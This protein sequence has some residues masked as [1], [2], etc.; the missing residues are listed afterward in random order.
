MATWENCLVGP[1]SERIIFASVATNAF[2]FAEAARLATN[3]KA[4]LRYGEFHCIALAV[5]DA[6][7]T[8][9][10]NLLLQPLLLPGR[11]SWR[12]EASWCKRKLSGWRHTSILKLGLLETVLSHGYGALVVD[13]DW[14]FTANP[15]PSLLGCRLDL[16]SMRDNHFVNIGLMLIRNTPTTRTLARRAANRSVAAWDQALI[17]EELNGEDAAPDRLPCCVANEFFTANFARKRGVNEAKKSQQPQC[18]STPRPHSATRVLGPPRVAAGQ[19][20]PPPMWADRGWDAGRFNEISGTYHHRCA[21][22]YNHCSRTRCSFRRGHSRSGNEGGGDGSRG[23]LTSTCLAFA[24]DGRQILPS[25]LERSGRDPSARPE[26]GP[27]ESGPSL[28][29]SAEGSTHPSDGSQAGAAFGKEEEVGAGAETPRTGG[30]HMA[31]RT[32]AK[33]CTWQNGCCERHPKACQDRVRRASAQPPSSRMQSPAAAPRADPRRKGIVGSLLR[34][35]GG[36][37][38]VH[39]GACSWVGG[40][41]QP[42]CLQR[43]T[44]RVGA[45]KE[46]HEEGQNLGCRL[47]YNQPGIPDF[48]QLRERR[49]MAPSIRLPPRVGGGACP[50]GGSSTRGSSTVGSST[51]GGSKEGQDG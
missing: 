12:P 28:R 27:A 22:C 18:I 21:G 6:V 36:N 24:Q 19:P 20:R 13:V 51:A 42:L 34:G 1:A 44:R 26:S 38:G 8:T 41:Q 17:N 2:Y 7:E 39:H 47:P 43:A 33:T 48:Q 45:G 16:I 31:P 32:G 14:R 46:G 5:S 35:G 25:S 40:V 9:P 10:A 49:P 29:N 4:T 23:G 50:T 11:A 37:G 30:T 15:L 3:A